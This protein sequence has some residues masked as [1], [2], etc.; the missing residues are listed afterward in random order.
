MAEMAG[1]HPEQFPSFIAAVPMN[2]PDG[3]LAEADRA[4]RDLGACGVQI[5]SNIAGAPIDTPEVSELLSLMAKLDRPI[6]LHPIRPMYTPDY[7]VEDYSKYE[8]WWALGWPYETSAAMYRLAF[9]GVFDRW[10][11]LKIITHHAGGMIPMVEGRL[12]SGMSAYGTRTPPELNERKNTP[13][14]G[15]PLDA[16]RK[17]YADT[18]TF[19]S[20]AGIECAVSFF[21]IDRVLFASDSPFDPEQGAERIRITLQAIDGMN[22]AD[23]ERTMI[24]SGNAKRLFHLDASD[25]SLLR[26]SKG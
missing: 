2:D 6:L 15:K 19:G 16:F 21:G 25:G 4:V 7:P 11:D 5:F 17:F 13:L 8:L 10:P 1:R 20:R 24:L 26:Q 12:D 23:D 18:A 22:L 9:T 3:M 14:K